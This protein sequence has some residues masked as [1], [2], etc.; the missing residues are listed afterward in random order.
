M[1]ATVS[2]SLSAEYAASSSALPRLLTGISV[3]TPV[4]NSTKQSAAFVRVH[5]V[6]ETV[7]FLKVTE[8]IRGAG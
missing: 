2:E 8:A 1:I 3:M 7:D 6:R 5:D 4:E